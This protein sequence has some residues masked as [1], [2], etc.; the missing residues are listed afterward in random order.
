MPRERTSELLA[1]VHGKNGHRGIHTTMLI[2]RG[3]HWPTLKKGTRACELSYKV[4]PTETAME[5]TNLHITRGKFLRWT[6]KTWR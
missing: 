1:L 6:C 4:P 5:Q 3:Q 2:G